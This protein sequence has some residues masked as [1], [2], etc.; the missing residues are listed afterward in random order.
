[1]RR[2]TYNFW[3]SLLYACNPIQWCK[4]CPSKGH[5]W[6][7]RL[8]YRRMM[9][10]CAHHVSCNLEFDGVKTQNP[11]STKRWGLHH[12]HN[13]V[14]KAKLLLNTP[15]LFSAPL[16]T[17]VFGAV[18]IVTINA[19]DDAWIRWAQ[20]ERADCRRIRYISEDASDTY[21]IYIHVQKKGLGL[22]WGK[23]GE[24]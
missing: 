14:Q 13:V 18:K 12:V 1:M 17:I 24:K 5:Q 6:N 7:R 21:P 16:C 15:V 20:P 23:K 3:H 8:G 4:M 19:F 11:S 22:I 10:M 9:W 2:L